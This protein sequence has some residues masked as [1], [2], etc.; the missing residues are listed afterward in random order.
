[1]K[2]AHEFE[3]GKGMWSDMKR[4][5]RRMGNGKIL[6]HYNFKKTYVT[7]VL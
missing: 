2:R 3:R 7:N 5:K 1:M 4:F 6:L